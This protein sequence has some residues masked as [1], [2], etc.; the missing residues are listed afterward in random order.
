MANVP[1]TSGDRL[2]RVLSFFRRCVCPVINPAEYGMETVQQHRYARLASAAYNYP[3]NPT[4]V[5]RI[6]KGFGPTHHLEIDTSLSTEEH[7]VVY[8]RATNE[9]TVAFRGTVPTNPKDIATDARILA[10]TQKTSER[11]KDSVQLMQQVQ[12]K[13]GSMEGHPR[14]TVCGHSLGGGIAAYVAKQQPGVDAHVFNAALSWDD[15][16][17]ESELEGLMESGRYGTMYVYSTPLD[18]V[19]SI[20]FNILHHDRHTNR[21]MPVRTVQVQNGIR[22]DPHS[23]EGNFW[24]RRAIHLEREHV[25]HSVHTKETPEETYANHVARLN[26]FYTDTRKMHRKMKNNLDAWHSLLDG[27]RPRKQIDVEGGLAGNK[28]IALDTAKLA[29]K[30]IKTAAK[31]PDDY[32]GFH[33]KLSEDLGKMTEG[34]TPLPLMGISPADLFND[35][36]VREANIRN[37]GTPERLAAWI[38]GGIDSIFGSHLEHNMD[39]YEARARF[40]SEHGL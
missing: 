17:G 27:K 16:F 12:A 21:L 18:P 8:D 9:V 39:V 22:V 23:L 13:Y 19:S 40:E 38:A 29:V 14:V 3:Q 30:M 24:D 6:L 1:L 37:P 5:K 34:Y 15:V 35:G 33:E 7:L 11:Y 4:E 10:G 2:L 36:H 26:D 32:E 20:Q 31:N 25:M 28:T